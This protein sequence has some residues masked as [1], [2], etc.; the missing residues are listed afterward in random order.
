MAIA[1]TKY[2]IYEKGN[3]STFYIHRNINNFNMSQAVNS[4]NR[5]KSQGFKEAK[6]RYKKNYLKSLKGVNQS[7]KE[8]LADAMNDD[9]ILREIDKNLKNSFQKMTSSTIKSVDLNSAMQK[10]YASLNSFIRKDDMQELNGLFEAI[11]EATKLLETDSDIIAIILKQSGFSGGSG[12]LGKLKSLVEQELNIMESKSMISVSEKK[13]ASVLKSLNSLSGQLLKGTKSTQVLQ[14]YL[15]NIFSTQMGEYVISKG[16]IEAAGLASK[17][18]EKTMVGAK[19][20]RRTND[21]MSKFISAF[22][23]RGSQSFKTDNSFKNLKMSIEETGDQLSIDLGISTKWYKGSSGKS[24]N[25]IGVTSETSFMNRVGQMYTNPN[26]KYYVYNALALSN[27]SSIGYQALKASIVARN[28]DIFLSGLGHQGDFSQ[29]MVVN[30]EFYSIYDIIN[31]VEKYNT[32]LGSSSLYREN[33]N[34]PITISAE[35]L[36]KVTE[37][38][39]KALAHKPN[40]QQ[41]Y[42]RSKEQDVLISGLSL[43][44]HFYPNRLKSL[45]K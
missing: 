14:G 38:T 28:I 19:T 41:A 33:A 40:L 12:D 30:G 11:S 6:S 44:G 10:G 13:I 3:G 27:Q 42:I 25:V 45:L 8:R 16:I 39:Q 32:G 34:D 9:K 4:F 20:V 43:K 37:L 17:E 1:Q 23:Q 35:G 21:D 24:K 36:S 22:G 26:Q 29:F 15:K 5:Q 7:A 18:I 2:T 31:L